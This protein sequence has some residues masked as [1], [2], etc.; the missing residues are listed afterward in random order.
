MNDNV[1]PFTGLTT[2]KIDPDKI[3]ENNK[4]VFE[5]VILVGLT[6][7]RELIVCGSH[8]LPETITLLEQAKIM[9]LT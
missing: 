4:G 9:M 5:T 6:H 3:L 7:D 2:Q 8:D 1:V